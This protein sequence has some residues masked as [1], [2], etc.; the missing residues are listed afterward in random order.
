MEG[1]SGATRVM[2]GNEGRKGNA[3]REAGKQWD[4]SYRIEDSLLRS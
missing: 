2:R 1:R 4:K 3:L